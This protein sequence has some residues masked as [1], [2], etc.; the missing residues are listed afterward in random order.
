MHALHKLRF[1]TREIQ[2]TY[3][4]SKNSSPSPCSPE[5]DPVMCGFG[6]SDGCVLWRQCH[7]PISHYCFSCAAVTYCYEQQKVSSDF[8]ERTEV[9]VAW[10]SLGLSGSDFWGRWCLQAC[11]F[12]CCRFCKIPLISTNWIP[13]VTLSPPPFAPP[14]P[15]SA[16]LF[17]VFSLILALPLLPSPPCS[18]T[19]LFYGAPSKTGGVFTA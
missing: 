18:P 17:F 2:S 15:L 4:T 10:K 6:C 14:S 5:R 3:V 7:L 1:T 19:D 13:P 8:I 9:N 11:L 16:A 12:Y